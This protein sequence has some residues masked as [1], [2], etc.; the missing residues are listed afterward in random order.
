ML[1]QLNRGVESRNIKRPMMSDLRESGRIEEDSDLILLLYRDEYYYPDTIDR[2]IA[3]VIVSK[4]RG[5]PTGTIKL[6]FDAQFT[7]L[8]NKSEIG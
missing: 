1:S 3:E 2:S 6:L 7:Q 8:K 5:G 4:N